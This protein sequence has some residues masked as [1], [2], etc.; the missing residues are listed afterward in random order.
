[1]KFHES[2]FWLFVKFHRN[3]T[4]QIASFQK[5][6]QW[7]NVNRKLKMSNFFS[8]FPH[9]SPASKCIENIVAVSKLLST[10][11][12]QFKKHNSK[13]SLESMEHWTK[14]WA[15]KVNC[16]YKYMSIAISKNDN[17]NIFLNGCRINRIISM[18]EEVSCMAEDETFSNVVSC[19]G[20]RLWFI[21]V[22]FN[23]FMLVSFSRVFAIVVGH[24]CIELHWSWGKRRR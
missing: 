18:A 10:H 3:F 22:Y 9:Q 5:Y 17:R 12:S 23:F 8:K 1:M 7:L 16:N 21:F 19:C 20:Y 13:S 15:H 6:D 14:R 11:Y 24:E 4:N 2:K